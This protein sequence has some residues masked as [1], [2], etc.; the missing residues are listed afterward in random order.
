MNLF[1]QDK[2]RL[3]VLALCLSLLGCD[4]RQQ[5][6]VDAQLQVATNMWLGYEPLYLARNLN[7]WNHDQIRLIDYPSST[8]M[9]RAFHNGSIDA[10]TM[11][12]DE[13]LG[14]HNDNVPISIILIH[15]MSHGGDVIM[16]NPDIHSMQDLRGK[17]VAVEASVLGA[18]VTTRA[19]GLHDL[20]TD[21]INIHSSHVNSHLELYLSGQIDA[22]VTYD[23]LGTGLFN[24]GAKEIFSS[25]EIPGEIVDVLVARNSS[26]AKYPDQL[27]ALVDGWF[28]A[29]DFLQQQPVQAYSIIAD[30]LH[31]SA[32]EVSDMFD[33]IQIPDRAQNARLLSTEDPQLIQAASSLNQI[34]VDNF[35]ISELIDFQE[36][37]DDTFVKTSSVLLPGTR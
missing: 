15:D 1:Q 30:R 27:Q 11:T 2:T 8:E 34:M 7:Y 22:A 28:N 37:P 31:V 19:L 9:L 17:T 14:L 18:L 3:L 33:G 12:L 5:T 16:A 25:R 4:Q 6:V 26:V 24:A 29:L 35:L 20:S 21:D 10:A 36:L 32:A 23:P 13:A